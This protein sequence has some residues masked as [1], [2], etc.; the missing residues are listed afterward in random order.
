MAETDMKEQI[1][2][3]MELMWAFMGS[4][5]PKYGD[6][7]IR[8]KRYVGARAV[9]EFYSFGGTRKDLF[10]DRQPG[11]VRPASTISYVHVFDKADEAFSKLMHAGTSVAQGTRHSRKRNNNIISRLWISSRLLICARYLLTTCQPY[12]RRPSR[13]G[14]SRSPG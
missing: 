11:Y 4:Y 10:F 8:W 1:T 3:E 13:S 2:G 14:V 6:A 9:K 5:L 12:Q 7:C